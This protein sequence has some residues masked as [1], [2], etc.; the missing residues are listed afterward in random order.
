MQII[1]VSAADDGHLPV[2]F[3]CKWSAPA[4]APACE[5]QFLCLS[6]SCY[7][8]QLPKLDVWN[9]ATQRPAPSPVW[10]LP[11]GTC[12]LASLVPNKANDCSGF[13][14]SMAAF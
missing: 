1:S 11:Q 2:L 7:S 6:L 5:I 4:I 14:L 8:H 3:P 12:H 13:L 10:G 9:S